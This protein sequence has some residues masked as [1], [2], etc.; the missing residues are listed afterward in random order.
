MIDKTFGNA[1]ISFELSIGP[2]G[3]LTSD[4]ISK[5]ESMTSMTRIYPSIPIENNPRHFRLPIDL[6]KPIVFTKYVFHDYSYRMILSNRLKQSAEHL[7]D[8]CF[9]LFI[10]ILFSVEFLVEINS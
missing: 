1:R 8:F 6:E 4:E 5:N 7:V 2:S 9:S 10:F 3:Y